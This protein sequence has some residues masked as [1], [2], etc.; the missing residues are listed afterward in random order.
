VAAQA[1][2]SQQ[3]QSGEQAEKTI[4]V[5]IAPNKLA[6]S[7]KVPCP[8]E[9]QPPYSPE[10]IKQALAHNG[11]TYGVDEKAINDLIENSQFDKAVVVARGQEPVAGNNANLVFKFSKVQEF[12]P[13]EDKDGRIDYRDL[14]F[15]QSATK[16][17]VLVEKI[18][19]TEG[20]PG[21]DILGQ[22]V[23][24]R[25]GRDVK[26]P[27]GPG[28]AVSEDG[29][30]LL[31]TIE[32]AIVYA[33]R[34]IKINDVHTIGGDVCIETGNIKHNGSLIIRGK[35]DSNFEVVAKGDIEIAKSVDDA[36]LVSGGNIMVKGGFLGSNRGLLKADGDVTVKYVN[37]QKIIS[38]NDVRIGG[39][40]F[41]T[42]IMAKNRVIVSGSRG[43]IVGGR[44]MAGDE[45]KAT[46]LGS[47][48]GTK[49]ELQVAYDAELMKRYHEVVTEIKALE[50]NAE[51]VKEGLYVFYRL[52]MDGK[53][54]PEKQAALK[55]LEEF[56]EGLPEARK[57]L[58]NRKK[59]LENEIQKNKNARIIAVKKVYPGVIL[60]F[61][62]VYKEI[63]DSMGPTIFLMDNNKIYREEYK[64]GKDD[65]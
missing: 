52:Q 48:A 10:D 15:I 40:A 37:D 22:P 41:N 56:K 57:D 64:P 27:A 49:T 20:T 46:C 63:T 26:F 62:I 59:A 24:A 42:S 1:A 44:I 38:G 50:E 16:G 6:A 2:N 43:R 47:D 11:V 33:S 36:K 60:Q 31:A 5:I 17:Q 28:T 53:L 34:I 18:P 13:K 14:D 45:I 58:E 12:K 30:K 4:I 35:V 54:T 19:P 61:G 55:K 39:E 32:G 21:T 9:G 7:V 51:R 3:A 23:S 29:T 8:E 25:S 65:F